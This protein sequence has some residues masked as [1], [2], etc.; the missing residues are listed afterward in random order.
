M[1]SRHLVQDRM[2]IKGAQ[3]NLDGAEA[4]LELR[5]LRVSGHWPACWA[6]PLR[7]E[8]KRNY[9]PAAPRPEATPLCMPV[10]RAASRDRAQLEAEHHAPH[11]T[12]PY[13]LSGD[14]AVER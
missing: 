12:G 8:H 13:E 2:G 14:R 4:I 10:G 3:W 6:F 7:R 11:I 9:A 1:S 5:A